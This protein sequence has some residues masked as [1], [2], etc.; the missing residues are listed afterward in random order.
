[1]YYNNDSFNSTSEYRKMFHEIG[2][3][4]FSNYNFKYGKKCYYRKNGDIFQAFSLDDGFGRIAIMIAPFWCDMAFDHGSPPGENGSVYFSS[5]LDGGKFNLKYFLL[6][7]L[8]IDGQY[9]SISKL[10]EGIIKFIENFNAK[11]QNIYDENTYVDYLLKSFRFDQVHEDAVIYASYKSGSTLY[12]QEFI[13]AVD[14]E[15]I[16]YLL[17]SESY[18]SKE[19]NPSLGEKQ[20]F[21][22]LFLSNYWQNYRFR[23]KNIYKYIETGET[24]I[25]KRYLSESSRMRKLFKKHFKIDF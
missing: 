23:Y 11:T 19:L 5:L 18:L 17:F 15:Q 14:S 7:Q 1:M 3:P 13:N 21:D 9:Y 6:D 22:S 8:F 20:Q 2:M 24:D 10:K 4:I 16:K 25:D 12:A